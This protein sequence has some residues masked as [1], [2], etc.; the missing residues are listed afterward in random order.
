MDFR[1]YIDR[2]KIFISI[3][4]YLKNAIDQFIVNHSSLNTL[5]FIVF[6]FYIMNIIY[7][8]SSLFLVWLL[9][10][11]SSFLLN[12]QIIVFFSLFLLFYHFCFGILWFFIFQKWIIRKNDFILVE[13]NGINQEIKECFISS[14]KRKMNEIKS[15]WF[16]LKMIFSDHWSRIEIQLKNKYLI[17]IIE[18]IPSLQHSHSNC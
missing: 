18:T 10:D 7:L 12:L 4:Y 5:H 6:Q 17:F 8:F 3:S 13:K 2:D 11:Y 1:L 15:Y 14:E 16:Y 9:D